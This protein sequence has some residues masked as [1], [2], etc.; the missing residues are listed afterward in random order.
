MNPVGEPGG[1][2]TR[3]NECVINFLPTFKKVKSDKYIT[4]L[5]PFRFTWHM[6]QA[7]D[8]LVIG[9]LYQAPILRLT[10]GLD[11]PSLLCCPND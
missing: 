8:S 11:T 9:R 7:D 1:L 10:H 4:E 6:N 3:I 5:S 2:V